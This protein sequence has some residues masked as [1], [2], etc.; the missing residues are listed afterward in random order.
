M[1]AQLNEH[2]EVEGATAA[3]RL[4]QGLSIDSSTPLGLDPAPNGYC[5]DKEAAKVP[6]SVSPHSPNSGHLSP[7]NPVQL[8]DIL[9]SF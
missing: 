9:T 5:D 6:E 8:N 7:I 4:A 3:Q 2:G 1:L